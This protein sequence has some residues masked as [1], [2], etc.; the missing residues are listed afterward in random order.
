[1]NSLN[2]WSQKN[3]IVV[4]HCGHARIVQF[5]NNP[6][7]A[8]LWRLRDYIVSGVRA[9]SIWLIRRELFTESEKT[10]RGHLRNACVGCS[11]I[12]IESMILTFNE[13]NQPFSRDCAEEFLM[14]LKAEEREKAE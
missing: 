14:E 10:V 12:E 4:S 7:R 1:M 9:G 3:N 6:N 13:T 5:D 11:T 8:D 2:Q